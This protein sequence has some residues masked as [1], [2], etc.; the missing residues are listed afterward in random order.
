MPPLAQV[1]HWKSL[2]LISGTPLW[3]WN[4]RKSFLPQADTMS[5]LLMGLKGR[6]WWGILGIVCFPQDSWGDNWEKK[7]IYQVGEK[8]ILGLCCKMI[9]KTSTPTFLARSSSSVGQNHVMEM[10]HTC[11]CPPGPDLSLNPV[12][13]IP[14]SVVLVKMTLCNISLSC[15]WEENE[16]PSPYCC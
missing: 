16:W 9:F 8:L 10:P 1:E 4:A 11:L 13:V 14:S 3:T 12:M 15:Q 2:R 5:E 6:S 7:E